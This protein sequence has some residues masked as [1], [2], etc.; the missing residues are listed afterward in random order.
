MQ[1][2]GVDLRLRILGETLLEEAIWGVVILGHV[3]L[4]VI[5]GEVILEDGG[6]RGGVSQKS[7]PGS[8]SAAAVSSPLGIASAAAF[9]AAGVAA[10]AWLF[11]WK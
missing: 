10:S 2:A 4:A 5:F 6:F 11:Q 1:A 8:G 7:A 9:A 3:I